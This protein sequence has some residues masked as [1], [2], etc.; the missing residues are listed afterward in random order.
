MGN[1]GPV[2]KSAIKTV[3]DNY[4]EDTIADEQV[5]RVLEPV[6]KL[7]REGAFDRPR[8]LFMA[9]IGRRRGLS[10]HQ[11]SELKKISTI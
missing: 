7:I 11:N 9:G 2:K 8:R 1:Y 4:I 5:R 10:N 6:F 3:F